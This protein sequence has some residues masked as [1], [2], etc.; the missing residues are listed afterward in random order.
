M[1]RGAVP[2][3][4]FSTA[5]LLTEWSLTQGPNEDLL[6]DIKLNH[7]VRSVSPPQ[8]EDGPWQVTARDLISQEDR[9]FEANIVVLAAGTIESPKIVA[10]SGLQDPSSLLGKGITDHPIRYVQFTIPKLSQ[11]YSPDGASNT[12]TQCIDASPDNHPYNMKLELGAD[13]NQGRFVDPKWLLQEAWNRG[14]RMLCELVFLFYS[15]L[16]DENYIDLSGAPFTKTAITIGHSK[17]ADRFLATVQ[18]ITDGLLG[19]L[20]AEA[21]DP[22]P[23][24]LKLQLADL[25][26]V[27]HEVGTLRISNDEKGLPGLVDADLRYHGQRR[28]YVCDL[29]VFPAAP[30]ANPSLTLVALAI[31]LAE[32][33]KTFL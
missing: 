30:A 25:G 23:N 8:K 11:Y 17:S 22:G 2:K 27:S 10:A 15:P 20:K 18:G 28:L 5:D 7:A 12:L 13:L 1:H 26:G 6:M 14:D 31:R 29:S 16:V 21:I 32:H 9:T 4:L 24:G 3:G 33:I 19:D